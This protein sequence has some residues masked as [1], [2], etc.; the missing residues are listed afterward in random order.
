MKADLDSVEVV[1]FVLNG[2]LTVESTEI[3]YFVNK[4]S[5]PL[6]DGVE[7]LYCSVPVTCMLVVSQFSELFKAGSSIASSPPGLEL[8]VVIPVPVALTLV[9]LHLVVEKEIASVSLL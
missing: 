6:I 4:P 1:L 9:V 3:S 2:C 7:P 8:K 5:P